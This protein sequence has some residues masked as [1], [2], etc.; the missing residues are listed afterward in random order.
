GDVMTWRVP[1]DPRDVVNRL[2]QIL[3]EQH[4]H[5]DCD[6]ADQDEPRRVAKGNKPGIEEPRKKRRGGVDQRIDEA[7]NRVEAKTRRVDHEEGYE[8]NKGGCTGSEEIND[9][10]QPNPVPDVILNAGSRVSRI[11]R[12][13]SGGDGPVVVGEFVGRGRRN[14]DRRIAVRALA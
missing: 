6:C 9:A 14:H 7:S 8:G 11:D 5:A 13:W 2:L 4:Q 3:A 10:A 12:V 1:G